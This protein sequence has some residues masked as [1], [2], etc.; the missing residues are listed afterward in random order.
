MKRLSIILLIVAVLTLGCVVLCGCGDVT[1]VD[2]DRK[3]AQ[4]DKSQVIE[5]TDGST[6]AVET[7]VYSVYVHQT[8]SPKFSLYW[9]AHKDHEVTFNVDEELPIQ[10]ERE[11]TCSVDESAS[12]SSKL[13]TITEKS[14]KD[15]DLTTKNLFLVLNVP[16]TW[17][18]AVFEVKVDVGAIQVEDVTVSQLRLTANTGSVYVEDCEV[19]TG[20]TA[21][22][23][24]ITGAITTND[25]HAQKILMETSTGSINADANA[26][27]VTLIADTGSIDFDLEATTINV[28]VDTG[29][30]NGTVEGSMVDYAISAQTNTGSCNLKNKTGDGVHSLTVTTDTGSIKVKFAK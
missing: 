28:S 11:G 2:I 20:T 9:V 21:T 16:E 5:V 8:E 17:T 29:S 15:V 23:K 4:C 19:A 10:K 25:L 13:V 24:S 18:T 12:V 6:I 26:T 22:I 1:K 27:D 30:V 14:K 7:D 3:L